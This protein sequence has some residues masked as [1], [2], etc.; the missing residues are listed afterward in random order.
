MKYLITKY[1]KK[2]SFY[3]IL[4]TFLIFFS[5]F[6]SAQWTC[7]TADEY[8]E[9]GTCLDEDGNSFDINNWEEINSKSFT[10]ATPGGI[11][12]QGTIDQEKIFGS[13]E[14]PDG[15]IYEG[16]FRD[17][18]Y[19]GYGALVYA[20]GDE[21]KGNFKEGE[22]NGEGIYKW[23][24]GEYYQ[25]EFL[26]GKKNG[27]G[28]YFYTDGSTYTGDFLMDEMTGE[29][30][31]ET[32][33]TTVIGTFRNAR[34][35]GQAE[36]FYEGSGSYKGLWRDGKKEGLGIQDLGNVV[37]EGSFKEDEWHGFGK[38]VFRDQKDIYLTNYD[39]GNLIS[40]TILDEKNDVIYTGEAKGDVLSGMDAHGQGTEIYFQEDGTRASYVGEFKEDLRDGYGEATYVNGSSYRGN[41][42]K[43][44]W[45]GQ[46][47]WYNSETNETYYGIWNNGELNGQGTGILPS[48]TYEGPFKEGLFHGVGKLTYPDGDIYYAEY[49]G[50]EFQGFVEPSKSELQQSR[51][52]LV[53]GNAN[54]KS[55]RLENTVS[56]SK[57]MKEVLEEL[58]FKVIHRTDLNYKS[59]LNALW[60]LNE[61]VKRLGEGATILVFYAGHAGQ[62][63]GQNYLQPVDAIWNTQSQVLTESISLNKIL[64]S[65]T[66]FERS[67]RIVILDSCRNNPLLNVQRSEVKGLAQ[68]ASPMGTFIAYST[69]PGRVALDGSIDGYGIYTGS[70]IN[71]LR[72]PGLSIEQV[73]KK[74]RSEVA[75]ITEGQQIPTEFSSLLGD[76]YFH[77]EE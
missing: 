75:R 40:I 46:G 34:I 36:A 58:N 77:I 28:T 16:E 48:F 62:V 39:R 42:S 54:Y 27:K 23:E 56:D 21:Y 6:F 74:T 64:D 11:F 73:F 69:S 22:F 51:I 35:H 67:T 5:P 2:I 4:G 70:L 10:V 53:I 57:G 18:L 41:W 13:V 14:Y 60:E 47:T 68:M 8:F 50:G 49:I 12:F 59:F 31:F 66:A 9:K 37:Y 61:T 55:S 15:S 7:T 52:A 33:T 63:D 72:T 71:S 29:A 17:K 24:D 32:E 25:G 43:G 26:K 45:M 30:K 44:D 76:F 20:N 65:I 1:N 3:Q 38:V 19:H